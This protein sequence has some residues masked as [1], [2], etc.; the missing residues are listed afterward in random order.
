MNYKRSTR[1][2]YNIHLLEKLKNKNI[3]TNGANWAW[4]EETS[5]QNKKLT[6]SKRHKDTITTRSKNLFVS[7][8]V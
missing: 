6:V 3:F 8:T 1:V 7:S 5:S 2:D 4:N